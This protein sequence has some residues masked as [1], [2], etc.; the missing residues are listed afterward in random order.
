MVIRMINEEIESGEEHP[1]IELVRKLPQNIR[2]KTIKQTV[3]TSVYGVTFIGA[4][5]QIQRQIK[6]QNF[7]SDEHMEQ[8]G[9]YVAKVTLR[10]IAN[11]FEGAHQIKEWLIQCS[12]LI[13]ETNN[14]VGWITPMGLPI[15][16]PYRVEAQADQI[17]TISNSLRLQLS[18]E[19]MPI[20]KLKQA[21]AFPPN[22]VHSLDSTHMLYTAEECQKR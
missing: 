14:P 1:N 16:Q 19:Q 15:V 17:N 10:A 13:G 21:S 18:K 2:R 22:F 6:D 4:K 7:I 12:R 9:A 5:R 11:L 20:N 3:M 8:A